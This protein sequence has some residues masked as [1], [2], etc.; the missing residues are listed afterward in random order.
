MSNS[1]LP[2]F[3]YVISFGMTG[4]WLLHKLGFFQIKINDIKGILIPSLVVLVIPFFMAR[5]TDF[6]LTEVAL[7]DVKSK[8]AT[9]WFEL[10]PLL[11]PFI[12]SESKPKSTNILSTLS[13]LLSAITA[14]TIFIFGRISAKL[15]LFWV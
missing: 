2:L 8:A 4:I 15:G 14:I 3:V 1:L 9:A 7:S 5:A 11:P 10:S 13:P 6:I 12:L